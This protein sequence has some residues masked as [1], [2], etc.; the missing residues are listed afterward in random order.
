MKNRSMEYLSKRNAVFIREKTREQNEI[1]EFFIRIAKELQKLNEL[2]EKV[3]KECKLYCVP[4]FLSKTEIVKRID[5]LRYEIALNLT[6]S[7]GVM[8]MFS[9][10]YS[11]SINNS[12]TDS[13][14][15]HF[16]YKLDSLVSR[17]NESLQKIE[18]KKTELSEKS[19]FFTQNEKNSIEG[20]YKSVYFISS[21]IRELKSVIISQS[22]KIERLD[23]VMDAISHSSEKSKKE[24]VSISAFGSQ[25]KNR[26]ITVLFCSIF[27]LV[28]L[29]SIKVYTHQ[30]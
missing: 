10:K 14:A 8:E 17:M 12:L 2:V 30:K 22:E 11:R 4:S 13:V 7:K 23:S 28:V 16:H 27:I 26:I 21:V 20:V 18:Q 6:K 1:E 5:L 15:S 29:S 24:I 19:S 9:Q 3:E 25:V